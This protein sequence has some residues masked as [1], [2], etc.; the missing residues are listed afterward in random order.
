VP[1]DGGLG[2]HRNALTFRL[3]LDQTYLRPMLDGLNEAIERYP[4]TTGGW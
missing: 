2:F 4:N 1:R 3:D